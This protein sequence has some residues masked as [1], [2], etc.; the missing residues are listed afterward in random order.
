MIIFSRDEA[1]LYECVSVRPSVGWSVT[2][3]LFGLLGAT[4]GRVS[5]L[6]LFVS[7]S[8]FQ[9]VCLSVCQFSLV[10]CSNNQV[11]L[12]FNRPRRN[13]IALRSPVCLT[14]LDHGGVL[15]S[16]YRGEKNS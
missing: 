7:L 6:V 11:G 13:K 2:L 3:S 4:Y 9:A 14:N 15:M 8:I 1:T 16:K 10:Y 12:W 5:G